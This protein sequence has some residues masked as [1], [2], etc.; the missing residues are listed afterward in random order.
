MGVGVV[1]GVYAANM[2]GRTF[3][4]AS[5]QALTEFEKKQAT[6]SR[7]STAP[8]KPPVFK[9]FVPTLRMQDGGL[10]AS[11]PPPPPPPR[12]HGFRSLSPPPRAHRRP[13]PVT[14]PPLDPAPALAQRPRTSRRSRWRTSSPPTPLL[15]SG[16]GAWT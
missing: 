5:D 6:L 11:P 4:K 13:R 7:P 3:Y 9:A 16:G 1:N 15:P 12:A 2:Y 10:S 14:A 8:E